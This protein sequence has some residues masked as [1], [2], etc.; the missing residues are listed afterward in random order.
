M[1]FINTIATLCAGAA[2]AGVASAAAIDNKLV[3]RDDT[4]FE[5]LDLDDDFWEAFQE[6]CEDGVDTKRAISQMQ[7][8]ASA[9]DSYDTIS[10]GNY[11]SYLQ[12]QNSGG[13]WT[14]FLVTCHGVIITGDT[15]NIIKS[16]KFL[17][18]FYATDSMIDDMWGKLS[19]EVLDSELTNLRA[20][21]SVPDKATAPG[22]LNQD[23]IQAVED[24]M[25]E[26]LKGL[27]GQDPTVRYHSMAD[28]TART[29]DIGTMQLN[30]AD[31]T[32][33]IDGQD[34]TFGT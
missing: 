17:A 18:H 15:D 24:K 11:K 2:F 31:S 19:K 27:T 23:D 1:R 10:P 30:N 34:I 14:D 4:P 6:A 26:L 28:A 8:R 7:P 32:V 16:N 9:P 33:K 25:K 22:D 12:F 20:Y 21:L 3:T 5:D 29:G 13:A